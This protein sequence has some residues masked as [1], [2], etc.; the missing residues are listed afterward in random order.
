M[1]CE[2]YIL[3]I[4]MS[5]QSTNT[6]YNTFYFR[7]YI[8]SNEWGIGHKKQKVSQIIYAHNFLPNQLS[9]TSVKY[10]LQSFA[11]LERVVII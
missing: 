9:T 3:Y 8:I 10:E 1:Y 2:E 6:F 4:F 5:I 7:E 11:M